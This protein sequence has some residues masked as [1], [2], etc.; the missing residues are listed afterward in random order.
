M[1]RDIIKYTRKA[2]GHIDPILFACTTLLS[3]IS[4]VTIIS[5]VDNFG[6]SKLVMQVAMFV[7]GNIIML[8]VANLDYH[9]VLDKLWLPM[10]V[11]SVAI[12]AITLVA[13]SSG[14]NM[15]TANQSWLVVFKLGT[16]KI[17]IQPSEFVKL[18]L[19]CTFA[20]HLDTVKDRVNHPVTLAGLAVHAGAI[21]GLIFLSG[22]YG[23]ALIYA[24]F[25]A[26]MLLCAGLS[27][28]YFAGGAGAA[29]LGFP[30]AW[31]YVLKE[32]HR[33]RIIVGFNPE[34]DPE[35][36]GW[37]PLLSKDCIANGG[38]FGIGLRQ[39]GFYEVLTAS[40]TDF[41]FSTI[42]EK[43]GLVGGTVVIALLAVMVLRVAMIGYGAKGDSGMLICAGVFG[44]LF[45][46]TLLNIGMCLAVLPV[47]GITLPFLSCGGSSMLA[48]YIMMGMA[49]SVAS[50]APKNQRRAYRL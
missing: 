37:Q 9:W 13:G 18:T 28:W 29:V 11:F 1:F 43:Y 25:L 30:L 6:K 19:T 50:H 8:I 35:G 47:I 48:T 38:F 32:Y 33:K 41:I 4:I 27:L 39:G 44:C 40:H 20:K 21:V 7:V 2:I 14:E 12:L 46:Q 15:E 49:H 17:M 42:C 3:I 31:K 36:K 16:R 45:F 34:L 10:I 24:G 22:D 26:I 5:A 23:V